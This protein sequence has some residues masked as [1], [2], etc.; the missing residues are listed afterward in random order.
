MRNKI[1]KG[2]RK[3]AE[4]LTIGAPHTAYVGEKHQDNV[5]GTR[6]YT[7]SLDSRC[8]RAVYQDLKKA[9]YNGH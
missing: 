1:A 7:I 8:T 2:L 6:T 5:K 9:Y 3:M 4:D